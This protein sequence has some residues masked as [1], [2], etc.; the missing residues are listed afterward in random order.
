MGSSDRHAP[1]V[2]EPLDGGN[3]QHRQQQVTPE[4]LPG[5]GAKTSRLV[6]VAPAQLKFVDR[7][8]LA[9]VDVAEVGGEAG[10]RVLATVDREL[11]EASVCAGVGGVALLDGDLVTG[12]VG[13]GDPA[14]VAGGRRWHLPD[15]PGAEGGDVAGILLDEMIDGVQHEQGPGDAQDEVAVAWIEAE[16]DEG[17]VVAA[18][19][20][21]DRAELARADD[22]V[23]RLRREGVAGGD[24]DVFRRYPAQ[25]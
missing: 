3:G 17:L 22:L 12:A 19:R 13:L 10:G 7:S 4:L 8:D 25:D 24:L 21:E 18:T 23:A 15:V 16:R 2:G 20:D 14:D 5:P 9:L 11:V 6:R 1:V